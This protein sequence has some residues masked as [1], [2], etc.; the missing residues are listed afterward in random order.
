MVG[1]Q[2]DAA[3]SAKSPRGA[4][5]EA[6]VQIAEDA[7]AGKLRF[8]CVGTRGIVFD[9]GREAHWSARCG[10]QF[11]DDAEMIAA[12]GAGA[13]DG[14]ADGRQIRARHSGTATFNQ[15]PL[16]PSTTWRQRV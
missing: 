9:D 12:E 16:L 3:C 8:Q 5:G 11:A 4:G 7:D 13:D 1:T 15:R 6:G 2:T 14:E 10:A